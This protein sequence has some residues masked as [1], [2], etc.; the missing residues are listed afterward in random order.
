MRCISLAL[1]NFTVMLNDCRLGLGMDRVGWVAV[2]TL[3]ATVFLELSSSAA[4]PVHV[5][6]HN[7]VRGNDDTGRIV[8]CGMIHMAAFCIGGD[9]AHCCRHF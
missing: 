4:N 6:H 1:Y 9:R 8:N 5:F 2:V 7:D 3:L